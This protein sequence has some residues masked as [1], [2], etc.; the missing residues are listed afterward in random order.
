MRPSPPGGEGAARRAPASTPPRIPALKAGDQAYAVAK[1]SDV[2]VEG[3]TPAAAA[4]E[5]EA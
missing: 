1:A 4:T 5:A 2:M 3:L